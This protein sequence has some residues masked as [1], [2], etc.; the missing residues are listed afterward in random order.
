MPPDQTMRVLS[1]VSAGRIA[2]ML[3]GRHG[4]NTTLLITKVEIIFDMPG[5][6]DGQCYCGH[7]SGL[8]ERRVAMLPLPKKPVSRHLPVSM[9]IDEGLLLEVFTKVLLA[10]ALGIH[11]YVSSLRR[12]HDFK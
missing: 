8:A 11:L 3:I 12:E 9:S 5:C 10:L 6:H 4:R 2:T 7:L 1:R